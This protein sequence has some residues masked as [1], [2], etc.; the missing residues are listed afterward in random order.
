MEAQES[1]NSDELK[2]HYAAMLGLKRPWL[3]G[4]VDLQLGAKRLEIHLEE[5]QEAG[6]ECP[7]CGRVCWLHDH[8]P[9][10]RWRHLDA[11]GF[12]T[13]LVASLPRVRC[14]EHGVKTANAPWADPHGR[15]TLA[16]EAFA[17]V[18]LQV[19]ANLKAAARLLGL[20]WKSLQGI[21]DRAVARGLGRRSVEE[22]RRVG[23]DEKSFG[24]GQDYI[25]VMCDLGHA[26]V[27]DVVPGRD[28]PSARALWQK[29][30]EEVRGRVQAVAMDMSA[31]YQNAT[32]I[33][34]PQARIVF[35]K[36][37]VAKH[38]GEAVDRTRRAEHKSLMA[39][40]D[41]TLKGARYLFLYNP[42]NLSAEQSASFEAL[43]QINLK[44]GRAWAYKELFSAFWEQ[45]GVEAARQFLKNW[46]GKVKRTRLPEMK[47][48]AA[49]IE[50]HSE[51]LLNY[52]V[53]RI[54]N[55]LCEGFNSRIQQLK[56]AAR[57]FRNFDNYRSRILFF[58]GSLSLA[59]AHSH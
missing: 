20:D 12:E 47:K 55:A 14:A 51:G 22:V 56:A 17:I 5:E 24:A 43:L 53:H 31:G 44:S 27:L 52:F 37:H 41:D 21:M 39:Q 29:L 10:R 40:G 23:L 13:L 46:L 9:A 33:E 34:A 1:Q 50:R 26:R 57:G 4:R 19:A 18:V 58:L 30:P 48:A 15:F 35:D 36:F 6:F 28:T 11:M 42:Q 25:S 49:T 16:F 3:V 45:P 2:L 54:T 8:A 38:L 59:P 7:E 32:R